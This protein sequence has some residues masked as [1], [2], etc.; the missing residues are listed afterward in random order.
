MSILSVKIVTNLYLIKFSNFELSSNQLHSV[1]LN[2][3][4]LSRALRLGKGWHIHVLNDI[5]ELCHLHFRLR[6]C[7]LLKSR[8]T[9]LNN[10]GVDI[11]EVVVLSS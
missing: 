7:A 3:D 1:K 4:Y 6:T 5:S 8:V 2:S 9:S 10:T 11:I